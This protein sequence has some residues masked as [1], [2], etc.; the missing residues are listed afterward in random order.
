MENYKNI[1]VNKLSFKILEN[2]L[3][4]KTEFGINVFKLDCGVQIIDAGIE[5][6]GSISA[7]IEIAKICMGG[8]G[9]VTK[10]V[11]NSMP[12][13]TWVTVQSEMPV[14]SCLGSQYAGWS[15]NASED[16]TGDESFSCLG[17]GP[18]R[19]LARREEIFN[20][21]KYSDDFDRG[22]I[23]MEVG[24]FPPQMIVNKIVEDCN[25]TNDSLTIV[26]THTTSLSGTT[27]VVSRVLEVALHKA[28]TLGFNLSNIVEGIATAPLPTPGKN[29]IT[30]MGRTNDAIL[31]GGT[32]H[33]WVKGDETAAKEL[34]ENLPSSES[35]QF[36]KSFAEIFKDVNFDF[37]KID[38]NLFA[39][40]KI[41]VSSFETGETWHKGKINFKILE[42]DWKKSL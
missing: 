15:L 33:L 34:A 14:L 23:I 4:K 12:W 39:P 30:A 3:D 7:G 32:V 8:L 17:S 2:L 28:H 38:P 40:S 22:V 9:K 37:Y 5:C 27:Q 41:W 36:G 21:I 6:K 31:Y 16:E 18:A 25:L 11:D 26:L 13:P 1:S 42:N 24:K 20:D 35:K 10:R 19:A 29:F